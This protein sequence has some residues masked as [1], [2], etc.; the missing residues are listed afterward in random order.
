MT[1]TSPDWD[2]TQISSQKGKVAVVTGANSGI[3]YYTALFLAT[4]GAHVI[5][6][7]RSDERGHKAIEAMQAAIDVIA[8]DARGSVELMLVDLGSLASVRSFADEFHRKFD[9]LD[10]LIN[11]AG[12]ATA[13]K[14]LT[15][16]GYESHFGV[17]HL[18][19]FYLT[20]LLFDSLKASPAARV[21]NVSSLAHQGSKIDFETVKEGAGP[22]WSRYSQS[23]M[24]NM[25]FT[26]ELGRRLEDSQ[27]T[28]IMSVAAHP[29]LAYTE[30]LDKTIENICPSFLQGAM[31]TII[32]WL[33]IQSSA[34]GALST[35]YAATA[36]DVK[37]KQFFGP[38]GFGKCFGYPALETP[39]SECF[40]EEAA[41]KLWTLSEE[42]IG[43]SF[44]VC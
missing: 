44:H 19:H 26:Q 17:N 5:L 27:L 31:K 34:I 3:G 42:L 36:D 13:S 23:K 6:A 29:G 2:E 20:A 22:G 14:P 25:L 43:Q 41:Q 8:S 39:D 32:A 37:S 35:L 7:C 15:S 16:D 33:P 10:L 9:R 1:T 4:H 38:S 11:N 28:N 40:S 30:G 18:A 12:M 24:A 21:V